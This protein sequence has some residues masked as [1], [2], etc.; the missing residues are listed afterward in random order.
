MECARRNLP[1]PDVEIME[2]NAGKRG[3]LTARVRLKFARVVSG[4]IL[5]GAGSHYSAGLFGLERDS[6]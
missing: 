5:L 6:A 3:G 1:K 2:W 4:P